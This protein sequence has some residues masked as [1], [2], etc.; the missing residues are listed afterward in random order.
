VN[1]DNYKAVQL[2]KKAGFEIEGK[3]RKETYFKGKYRDDYRMAI[4]L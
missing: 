3:L 4:F 2:Y 1:T